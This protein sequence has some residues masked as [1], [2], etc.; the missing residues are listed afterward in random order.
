M[1]TLN[2]SQKSSQATLNQISYFMMGHVIVFVNIVDDSKGFTVW[3]CDTFLRQRDR[4]RT[5]R[6]GTFYR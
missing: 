2:V 4:Q 6:L 1:L 3:D 5:K